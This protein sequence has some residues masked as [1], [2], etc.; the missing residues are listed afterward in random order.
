MT[1][2]PAAPNAYP[3]RIAPG[4]ASTTPAS[5]DQAE[6]EHHA[7]EPDRGEQTAE[8]TALDDLAER[9]IGDRERRRHDRVVAALRLDPRE[10]VKLVWL[11]AAFIA[12]VARIA[13]ATKAA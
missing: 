4:I 12:V 8:T 7:H 3:T 9:D 1:A 5:D 13:G 2:S 6:D 10:D 11:K